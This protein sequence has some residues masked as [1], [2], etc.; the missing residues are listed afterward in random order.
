MAAPRCYGCWR[1]TY[2]VLSLLDLLIGALLVVVGLLM[3]LSWDIDLLLSLPFVVLGGSVLATG[4]LSTCGVCVRTYCSC[5]VS[6]A[7]P[8]VFFVCGLELL[9]GILMFTRVPEDTFTKLDDAL[10]HCSG[11]ETGL[12]VDESIEGLFA[13]QNSSDCQNQERK[14]A[15]Q[16]F[17]DLHSYQKP[18]GY[19]LIVLAVLQFI[20][21]YGGQQV[22]R[23]DR[24]RMRVNHP[25]EWLEASDEDY[26]S[27]TEARYRHFSIEEK[28]K[29]RRSAD[30]SKDRNKPLLGGDSNGRET[31]IIDITPTKCTVQ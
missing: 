14:M 31:E 26:Q 28:W 3:E 18:F 24:S 8:L 5:C 22:R 7:V 27:H 13:Q 1:C 9:L 11:S 20:R 25:Q 4:M 29:E 30:I 21:F 23:I 16:L 12:L 19:S 6:I 17:D 2:I 15:K 10:G